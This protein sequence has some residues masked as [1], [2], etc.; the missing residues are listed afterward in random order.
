MDMSDTEQIYCGAARVKITPDPDLMPDLRGLQDV[1]FT[2]V[3][4]D[5]YLRVLALKAGPETVLI[6]TFDLD[7]VPCPKEY[8]EAVEEETAIPA[9]H[10]ALMAIHTH[11]APVAGWRPD[12]G[13]N[14]IMTKPEDVQEATHKYEEF[15]KGKL[16]E[17]VH[18]AL[19]AMVPAR[20]G[21]E[22]GESYINVNRVQDYR[23]RDADGNVTIE[24]GLGKNPYHPT[25]RRLFVLK[26]E[27]LDGKPIAFLSNY[28]VHNDV[29]IKNT[30]GKD[31]G[32]MLSSD[33]GGNVSQML[34]EMYPGAVA[35]WTSG[36][37]GDV[38]PVVLNEIFYPDPETGAQ[39]PYFLPPGDQGP[40]MMMKTLACQYLDD[41][42]AVFHHLDCTVSSA[43]VRAKTAW[44][45]TPGSDGKPYE[46]RVQMIRI[47]DLLLTGF[48]GELYT[49]LGQ[50][51]LKILPDDAV[52]INHDA[53]LLA[54]SGYI[55]DDETMARDTEGVLP[56]RHD[57]NQQPGYIKDALLETVNG[58]LEEIQ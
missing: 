42:M 5:I 6:V 54:N 13:P 12:E 46:V 29:L 16:L 27:T 7:K 32:E 22:N 15:L 58:L 24:C 25:D 44:A 28:A 47:G 49:S 4:D 41:M 19:D 50:A 38:N 21:W 8:A 57:S 14:F 43:A 37:A 1:T 23:V 48:S 3:L 45:S 17:A 30:C 53:S 35:L 33:M 40:I 18:A 26:A 9:D 51:I 36:A 56:G 39:T 20:I 11:T 10:I 34:E 2:E 31:G 52:V 55:F